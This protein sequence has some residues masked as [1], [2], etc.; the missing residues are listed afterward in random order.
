MRGSTT[1]ID[2]PGRFLVAAP[3]SAAGT[4]T[5]TRAPRAP[6]GGAVTGF[7]KALAREKPRRA[8]EGG[9]L[10]RRAASP[11]TSP[12]CLIE[13]TLRDPGAVEIGQRGRRCAGRRRSIERDPRPTAAGSRLSTATRVRGHRRG[14]QHRLRDH[15]RP[16]ERLG[17][18]LPPARPGADARSGDADL[19]RFATDRTASSA[20]SSSGSSAPASGPRRCWSRRSWPA[21]SGSRAALGAIEAV[22][23]AGGSA[24]YHSVDL[25]DA[26]RGGRGGDAEVRDGSGRIDVLLHA[27]GLEI[28]HFLPDKE[29]REF[30]LVFDVKSD[31]WFNLLHALGDTAARRHGGR[32]ARSPAASATAARPTTA[33]PTTCCARASSS[34]RTTRPET[35]GVAIDWTAWGGI[36]MATRGSIPTMMERPASTCCRPRP[37]SRS[38]AAS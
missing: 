18:H 27:A 11:P 3:G 28:S 23:R 6:L 13:E 7:T 9:R 12:T 30:D 1:R 10:R 25:T 15:R 20:T 16:G 37:A 4:A 34:L 33:R 19:E 36:G 14:G 8:G 2:R 32:S 29:P 5:T 26:R 38:C 17:R 35:R 22:E 24:H 31:G 21:S